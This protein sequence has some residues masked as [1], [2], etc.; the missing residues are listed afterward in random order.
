MKYTKEIYD[1]VREHLTGRHIGEGIANDKLIACIDEL[2]RL[3]EAER[4]IPVEE[5]LPELENACEYS[6][7]DVLVFTNKGSID[8]DYFN[9]EKQECH[10]Y[11]GDER[12]THCKPLPTPPEGE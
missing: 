1:E 4:W 6:S 11:S 8:V 7:I 10:G 9:I 2:D 5:S 12:V 3:H